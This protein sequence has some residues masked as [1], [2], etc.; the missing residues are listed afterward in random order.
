MLA[1]SMLYPLRHM[2][3][4][5]GMNLISCGILAQTTLVINE[6]MANPNNGQLPPY[7]YI[8]LFNNSTETIELAAY[9]IGIGNTLVDLPSYSLSP[10]QF[11]VLCSSAALPQFEPFGDALA[12]SRWPALNNTGAIISLTRDEELIDRVEYSN[13]WYGSTAKRNGG[14]SLERIN[15]NIRCNVSFNWIASD[16]PLGGTPCV[17]NSVYDLYRMPQIFVNSAG[18]E[19]NKLA[20]S[21]NTTVE[22]MD[23]HV[24]NFEV[25]PHM[26]IP[27]RIEIS[28]SKDT[29]YLY[30]NR[31]FE[32]NLIYTLKSKG[33]RW[34]GY[35]MDVEDMTLFQQGDIQYNDIVINEVL[36]NPRPGGVDFVEIL[37]RSDHPVNLQ[38]WKLGTRVISTE[39]LFI[40][41]GQHLALTTDPTV[42][43]THYKT[44]ENQFV[45]AMPRLPAYA[46]QKGIVTLFSPDKMIDS[47]SYHADMHQPFLKNEKGISLERQS[48]DNP[49]NAHD[50][51]RSA[52]TWSGGATPGYKNSVQ[53]DLILK[54][55]KIFLSSK[56]V[57]PDQDGFEDFLEIN[58]ELNASDYMMNVHIFS[59]SGRLISRLIRQQSA[60]SMGKVTWDCRAESGTFVP[61]GI[62]IF[63]VEIYTAKGVREL[64]KGG[65]VV[66]RQTL[67]Y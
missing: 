2:V 24:E 29:L 55:N 61:S 7:E 31:D 40:H 56:T 13:R 47:L 11:V 17:S 41:P 34:C 30:F 35:D 46:N 32:K 14:W 12:L 20:L 16:H 10:Q 60:G 8:E 25:A 67:A 22:D 39:K 51:F 58:Y 59:E 21:W 19:N 6:I 65:F 48:P 45:H 54:K 26:G 43:Y 42:L 5:F 52:S 62:Y 66:T 33:V 3:L 64:Q 49:T 50:N 63:S 28:S 15:P 4:M 23:F 27:E 18:I 1:K 38:D 37:N 44:D 57:S 9:R 36:F 53:N